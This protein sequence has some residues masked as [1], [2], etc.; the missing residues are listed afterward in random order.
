MPDAQTGASGSADEPIPH[1]LCDVA[2][3]AAAEAAPAGALWRLAE[4][5]RQLDA[6]LVRIPPRTRVDTHVEPDLDVL[7]LVVTGHGT[8]GT[9]RGPEPLTPGSL[10]W[11]PR[12]SSRSLTAGQDGLS[13]LTVHCRRPGMRIRSRPA[14]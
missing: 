7:L 5:G 11:L 3:L 1:V 6:N 13:Y 2:S 10:T 4:S 9:T 8:L 14:T 12:D